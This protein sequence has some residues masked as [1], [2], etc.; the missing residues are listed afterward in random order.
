MYFINYLIIKESVNWARKNE[1][2]KENKKRIKHEKM[3]TK[4]KN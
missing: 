4:R 2:K 3:K 1:D